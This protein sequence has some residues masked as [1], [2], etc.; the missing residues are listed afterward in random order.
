MA[1]RLRWSI[2]KNILIAS[3]VCLCL[4]A[5]GYGQ[6]TPRG[7]LTSTT[8]TTAS[9]QNSVWSLDVTTAQTQAVLVHVTVGPNITGGA[10]TFESGINPGSVS[11]LQL[12]RSSTGNA[13]TAYTLVSNDIQDWTGV[14]VGP[15]VQARLSSVI[16]TSSG[17][18]ATT[19]TMLPVNFQ[20]T[21]PTGGG[22]QSITS[23]SSNGTTTNAAKID[24]VFNTSP[25]T[26]L[27]GQ[28]ADVQCTN[29]G[30]VYVDASKTPATGAQPATGADA[31][32][33]SPGG[34]VSVVAVTTPTSVTVTTNPTDVFVLTGSASKVIE[35]TGISIACI[36]STAGPIDV[37][38]VA[39]TTIDTSGTPV[40]AAV[41][42]TSSADAATATAIQYTGNPTLGTFRATLWNAPVN[43]RVTG[44]S[45]TSDPMWYVPSLVGKP[46]VL[47][48]ASQQLAINLGGA[49]AANG[50]GLRIVFTFIER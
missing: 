34:L 11:L 38:L 24:C 8:W 23:G 22:V 10:I 40:T 43:C 39:R 27:S 44:T 29:V 15:Y 35:V 1:I 7:A 42:P 46:P 20:S 6:I 48:T 32:T 31:V 49:A 37:G 26:V 36:S 50:A 17:S 45:I 12:R 41:F 16:T 19:V 30:T 47:L 14:V 9:A 3:L 5:T 4:A 21:A 2:M 18:G 13:D 25:P 33:Q 28:V